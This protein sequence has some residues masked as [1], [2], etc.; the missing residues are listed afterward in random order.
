MIVL[1]WI[2]LGGVLV[3]MTVIGG[4][5]GW[6]GWDSDIGRH[7]AEPLALACVFWPALVFGV[8]GWLLRRAVDWIGRRVR[9]GRT[10]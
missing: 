2:W 8:I 7:E 5:V 9:P 1:L 10:P 3:V 4:L 6:H